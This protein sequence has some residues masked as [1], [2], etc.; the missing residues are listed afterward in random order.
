MTQLVEPQYCNTPCRGDPHAFCGGKAPEAPNR[1]LFNVFWVDKDEPS[2]TFDTWE[3]GEIQI[4]E[5]DIASLPDYLTYAYW[6]HRVIP[7]TTNALKTY[8][9]T[10]EV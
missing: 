5:I 7:I 3:P 10:F 8:K 4:T 2:M 9:I 6:E 1:P